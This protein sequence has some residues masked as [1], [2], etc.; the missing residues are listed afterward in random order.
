MKKLLS[1][2][3][4]TA[5][6]LSII[7]T[8]VFAA[9][10]T[11]GQC[12]DNLTWSYNT[13][14]ATL[15]ISGTGDMFDF[16][17]GA[18]WTSYRSSIRYIVISDR[19]TRIGLSAFSECTD[20]TNVTIPNSVASIGESAFYDC[21]GLT[22]ITVPDSVTSIGDYAFSNCTGLTSITIPDSVRSIG[23]GAF[24]GC[25]GLT[26]IF[27]SD[28]V[29]SIG[30]IAFSGCSGLSS[31]TVGTKNEKYFSNGNCLI[32]KD[33][34]KLILGCKNSV[35]PHSVTI[36]D[37]SA[38]SNCTGLTSINIPDS[39][40]S[41]GDWAF[42]N[43]TGLTSINIPDSVKSIGDFA[44]EKCTGL[45]S[46]A[47]PNSVTSIG[48]YAF[49]DCTGLTSI[50]IPDSVR[51]IG[52]GAFSDCTGLTS[53]TI[54]DSVT[55]IGRMAFS[56]CSGLSSIT[57]GT[58]NEKYFSNGNCLIEKDTDK[59]ILG[60]KNSVI[61]HSVTIIGDSAFYGCTGLTGIT[62][63]SSVTTIDEYAFSNCTGLTGITIPSS[64]TTIDEYAFSNCTGLTSITIP[65]SVTYISN[66]TFSGCTGLTSI[67]IPNSV[68]SI[69]RKAF[70]DCSNLTS[71]TIPD[72]VTYI[73]NQAFSDCSG[74][75]SIT[76]GTKNE[77]YF[78]SGNCVIEKD[79]NKLILGC[80][81][82]VI[83]YSVRSIGDGA[84]SGCTG[85]T[86]INIPY[87]VR[88]IGDGAFS[89]CTGLSSLMVDTKNKDYFSSGNCIITKDTNELILGC[90]N[91]VIPYSV[92]SIGDSAF[93]GCT[94]LTGI[95]IPGSVTSI[96]SEAF[97]DCTSLKK[98]CY[99]DSKE[100]W[101]KINLEYN[102]IPSDAEIIYN[103]TDC[104][105][106]GHSLGEWIAE[107]PETCTESGVKGH[108]EC[109]VCHKYLDKDKNEITDLAIPAHHTPVL[110]KKI[111]LTCT[112]DG[113]D[114]VKCS[115][116]GDRYTVNYVA[117]T[118]HKFGEWVSE[119]PATCTE[120]GVKGHYECFVCHKYF[121]NDKTEIT[122]TSI[123][124]AGHNLGEWILRIPETCTESGVR[125][126]YECSVCHKYFDKDK[127]EITDLV[128]P[129][130]HD[131]S[132]IKI[133]APTCT[134]DGYDTVKCLN[135]KLIYNINYVP[136]TGHSFGDW[137][138]TKK[139]TCTTDG[140][141]IRRCGKCCETETRTTK[142]QGHKQGELVKHQNATCTKDGGDY[143]KC[144][145]CG[146]TYFVL[147]VVKNGHLFFD[148][149]C[150]DCGIAESDVPFDIDLDC[151]VSATDLT[152]LKRILLSNKTAECDPNGDGKLNILDL[153]S[154][155]KRLAEK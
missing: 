82:S 116:C 63:P 139:L 138:V 74:L 142:A 103:A 94:G 93:Y 135:C 59:L 81:N 114:I 144:L 80:K 22:S 18:P 113:Y 16:Y 25:T 91:S 8:A 140:V 40:T 7:P 109:S 42:S 99:L 51:S 9:G 153:I 66:Q 126:H 125:E 110:L 76:V 124:A 4:C 19:I 73:S 112:T 33:T 150:I 119:I 50:T 146:E 13:A 120:D 121:D 61:P 115:S 11:S 34:D 111:P 90:K 49:S 128:I 57:V 148:G 67:T 45:T 123:P 130:H 143:Y 118:G 54:P 145:T 44:F 77:N 69:G 72:S 88:S 122:D 62:I 117:A 86:S 105:I 100:E 23:D 155:K 30:R 95:T 71:I 70:S 149:E 56:S 55:S 26:S 85:L 1:F 141:E 64:V 15:T 53:I 24:Y 38:F 52:D 129:A 79:T 92:T 3:I 106:N 101:N 108:Y 35:I 137:T 136:A 75:S 31:I 87:R 21:S 28:S 127:N 131:P 41:I 107:V 147:D 32:E 78:S 20:L 83:P 6:I 12:G 14:T 43:C 133:T 17:I 29:T 37:G 58:K 96:G 47:I 68:T 102:C 65:D 48:D 89:D 154:L 97:Y 2:L 39:V 151:A 27:I 46:I 152:Y 98:I 36:I 10:E 60:C 132:L 5:L 134:T 84:F 104:D